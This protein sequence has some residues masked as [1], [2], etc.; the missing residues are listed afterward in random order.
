VTAAVSVTLPVKPPDG[1]TVMVEVLLEVAPGATE[2]PVP[3]TAK[4]ELAR[5][6]TEIEV[7][8][9]PVNPAAAAESV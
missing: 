2:T 6:V 9:A 7:L 3:V 8:V 1:V 5:D 4:V